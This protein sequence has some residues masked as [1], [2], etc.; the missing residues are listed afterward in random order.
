MR[1]SLIVGEPLV[2]RISA[3][4]VADINDFVLYSHS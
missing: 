2:G 3:D 1:T 4:G